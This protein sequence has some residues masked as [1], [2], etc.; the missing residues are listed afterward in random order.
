MS[1]EKHKSKL[2]IFQAA[3]FHSQRSKGT[4]YT[5]VVDNPDDRISPMCGLSHLQMDELIR[6][7]NQSRIV[8]DPPPVTV[9]RNHVFSYFF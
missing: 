2:L 4:G 3:T 7:P 6:V 1:R 8:G 9:I 5:K